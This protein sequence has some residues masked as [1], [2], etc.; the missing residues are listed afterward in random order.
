MYLK[1]YSTYLL[2]DC[3]ADRNTNLYLYQLWVRKKLMIFMESGAI[4]RGNI[5]NISMS[6]RLAL[7]TMIW[8]ENR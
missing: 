7:G 5:D 4:G 8:I 1:R 2:C 3:E 6:S